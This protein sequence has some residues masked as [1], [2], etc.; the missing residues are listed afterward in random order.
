MKLL[1]RDGF[2]TA[3]INFGLPGLLTAPLAI[4][5]PLT[6][7]ASAVLLLFATTAW[8]GALAALT[9]LL[10]F[11]VVIGA[12]LVQGRRPDCHCFGQLRAKPIGWRTLALNAALAALAGFVVW[13]GPAHTGS[14][15]V[16]WLGDLTPWQ[17]V[18]VV[19][20][21]ITAIVIA[22][23]SWF[24]LQLFRQH[25]RLLLRLDAL[26]QMLGGN[27]PALDGETVGPGLPVGAPAPA[28]ELPDLGGTRVALDD[29]RGAGKPVLLVFTD[30]GC[31]PCTALVPSLTR[32]Q[33]QLRE[34]LTLVLISRGTSDENRA[35]VAGHGGLPVLLQTDREVAEAYQ[36]HGTPAAVV[37][38]PDGTIG[39]PVAMGSAAIERLLTRT[40]AMATSEGEEP[41]PVAAQ[42]GSPAPAFNLP[43][44]TGRQV[45]LETFRGQPVLVLFWNPGCGFCALPD[46]KRWEVAA[47]EGAPKLLVVSGGAIAANRAMGLRAPV[48]LDQGFAVGQAFGAGGTP[49]AVLVDAE[50]RIASAVAVGA[51]QV[52]TLLG[53]ESSAAAA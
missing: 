36:A 53:T 11:G 29:L 22:A 25:G 27:L 23:Q 10:A 28:F 13:Q 15:A 21:A 51:A 47:P 48:L 50:G 52:F 39:S 45:T 26:E 9:L 4:A 34:A 46:L 12:N 20:G 8:W 24:L 6:E 1:D 30:P 16:P 17:A 41:E 3:L 32:W 40:A 18:G 19:A 44:L 14:S 43:D 5:L 7:L 35:K 38:R 42:L 31:G 37:V 33:D 2:R 49:S